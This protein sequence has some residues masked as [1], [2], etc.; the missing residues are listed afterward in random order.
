MEANLLEQIL[1][2][3]QTQTA[4]LKQIMELQLAQ[5]EPIIADRG[6]LP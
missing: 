6:I 5:A 4:I 2:E 3:L 1:E